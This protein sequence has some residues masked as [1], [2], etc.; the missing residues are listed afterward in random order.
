MWLNPVRPM[1]TTSF[2]QATLN[3]GVGAVRAI[4]RRAMLKNWLTKSKLFIFS[5]AR[6]AITHVIKLLKRVG[7]VL[8]FGLGGLLVIAS[9]ILG[10]MDPIG[11]TGLGHK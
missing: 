10:E 2:G 3:G 9:M 6:S 5:A 4:S 1:G 8:A 7:L 11:W